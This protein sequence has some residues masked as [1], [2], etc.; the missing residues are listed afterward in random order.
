MRT[1]ETRFR[2]PFEGGFSLVEVL[3]AITILAVG[4]LAVAGMQSTSIRSNY[5]SNRQA[6]A[7]SLVQDQMEWLISLDF[8]DTRLTD[9]NPENNVNLTGAIGTAS[10]TSGANNYDGY[11]DTGIDRYGDPGGD[12][13]RYYNVADA[14][15]APDMKTIA[16]MVRWMEMG[17]T[18]FVAIETIIGR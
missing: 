14:T 8:T 6:S 9:N 5:A 7:I 4:I 1:G 10:S 12:F 17:R 16:V 3:I 13:N 15:P 18:R 2:A 11:L